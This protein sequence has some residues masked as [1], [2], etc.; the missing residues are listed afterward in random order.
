MDYS[1]SRCTLEA[2]YLAL[3]KERAEHLSPHA[4]ADMTHNSGEHRR[5]LLLK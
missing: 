2:P 3:G 5:F 1:V 4:S